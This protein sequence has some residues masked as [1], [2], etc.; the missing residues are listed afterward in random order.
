MCQ[1]DPVSSVFLTSRLQYARWRLGGLG[2]RVIGYFDSGELISACWLGSN[3]IPVQVSDYTAPLLAEEAA[4]GPRRSSSIVG[5]AYQ[6]KALWE[7]LGAAWGPPREIRADQP[8]MM[9]EGPPL[10]APDP[11]VSAATL[12]DEALLLPASVSMFTEEVGYSPLGP[13]GGGTYRQRVRELLGR[14]HTLARFTG[15][16]HRSV[17]FK[18]DLG[19]VTRQTVQIQ[20]VWVDPRYRGQGLSAPGMASV[21]E[22]CYRLGIP[23]ASLY[24][25]SFNT[26]ALAAY[27]RVGFR[28]VGSFA[29]VLF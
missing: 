25:N 9:I 19:A 21:V 14:G 11:L 12:A 6:V 7:N 3:T 26:R 5:P 10:V 27:R 17:L 2:G 24:V 20:G 4:K 1:R 23:S 28:K 29:T 22:Y 13:D 18:A 8:L 15:A 16:P